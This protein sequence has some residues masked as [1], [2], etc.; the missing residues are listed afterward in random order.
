MN[1]AA[2][3]SYNAVPSILI[4]APSGRTKLDILFETPELF[5]TALRVR[6]RVADDDLVEKAVSKGVVTA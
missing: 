6:G 5:S 2:T 1:I 4:V 3:H